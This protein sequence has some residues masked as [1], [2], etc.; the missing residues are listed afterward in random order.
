M[1]S[2]RLKASVPSLL[3]NPTM[4]PDV[5][6]LP[7]CKVPSVIL[8]PPVYVLSAEST[9]V[10]EPFCSTKPTPEMTPGTK[11]ASERLKARTLSFTIFPAIEPEVPP[12]PS[13][14]VPAEIVVRPV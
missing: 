2:E 3:T 11:K 13:C 4:E 8:V 14:K 1:L 6:P 5:P 12:L 10:P 9:V 7:I